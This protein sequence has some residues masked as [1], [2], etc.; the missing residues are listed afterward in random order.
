MTEI[1]LNGAAHSV[2]PA[3]TLA[4][5]VRALSLSNQAVALAVNRTVVPRQRWH[6]QEIQPGDRID[7]VRA[8]GGG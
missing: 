5:L 3:S 4:E 8:I 7:V 1:M 6:D 2:A